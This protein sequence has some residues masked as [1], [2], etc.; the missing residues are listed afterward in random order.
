MSTTSKIIKV[1]LLASRKDKTENNHL[2][3]LTTSCVGVDRKQNSEH[4][5][6]GAFCK[7]FKHQILRFAVRERD[8]HSKTHFGKNDNVRGWIHAIRTEQV[9]SG[10]HT[11]A[12]NL[13]WRMTS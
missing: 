7:P 5:A 4:M 1:K 13:I 12:V 11:T 3:L 9:T 2:L 6:L 10:T 8:T